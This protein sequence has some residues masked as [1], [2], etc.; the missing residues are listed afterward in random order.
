MNHSSHST[1]SGFSLIELVVTMTILAILVGVVS[2]RSG[3]LVEKGKTAK[4]LS[5][6]DT[7]RTA[8]SLYHADTG[9]YAY[10]YTN[11]AATH[12][13]L[14]GTQTSVAG[15]NGPYI[16]APLT[17]NGSNPYGSLHVYNNVQANSW[18]RGF[19]VDGDGTEDVTSTGNMLWLS[20][21]PEEA[22]KQIDAA[23]DKGVKGTWTDS[24]RVRWSSS[25]KYCWILLYY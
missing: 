14:S 17:H 18:I 23:L 9:Q 11:Y 25:S 6:V 3:S 20:G 21:I 13:K 7:L 15:W 5:L 19:D 1:R 16:E 4:I 10:E 8:C 24:G 22:A 12:R 2:F